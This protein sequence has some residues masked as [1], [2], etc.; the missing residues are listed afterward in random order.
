MLYLNVVN[1]FK[2]QNNKQKPL[3]KMSKEL[4]DGNVTLIGQVAFKLWIKTVKFIVLIN[5]SQNARPT[6]IS[7]FFLRSVDNL[8]LDV[9][10]IFQKDWII[11]ELEHKTCPFF[12]RG[13][14]PLYRWDIFGTPHSPGTML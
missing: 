11:F 2:K 4:S 8:L 3:S 14:V 6:W 5:Y 1:T 7:M 9:Y 13:E 12:I 10:I